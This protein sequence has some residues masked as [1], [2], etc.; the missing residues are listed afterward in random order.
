[1]PRKIDKRL[2]G[3]PA[4]ARASVRKCPPIPNRD[5]YLKLGALS[6]ALSRLIALLGTNRGEDDAGREPQ[7]AE[8][9]SL[10]RLAPSGC[11]RD[12]LPMAENSIVGHVQAK[13]V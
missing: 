8:C 4:L 13:A 3:L 9:P 11:P 5:S 10:G 2:A 6:L 12:Q 7:A 1:M